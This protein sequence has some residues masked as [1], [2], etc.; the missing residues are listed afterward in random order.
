MNKK[1]LISLNIIFILIL[2]QHC[3]AGSWFDK[4]EYAA[5]RAKFMEQIP[6]GVAV[7]L[8]ATTPASD[9]Q[10][11]QSSDFF[12]FT[13]VEIP[14]AVLIMDGM[15]KVST[16]FF[17]ISETEAQGEGISLELVRKPTEVTGIERISPLE[18]LSS[19][20]SRLSLQ[21]DVFYTMFRSEELSRE[22][23]NEKFRALQRTMTMN[24][25]D[26]RLTRE[27][28][29]VKRLKEKFP[30]ITVKDCSPL[31]WNLRK[32]KSPAEIDLLRKAGQIG[33]K[34]HIAVM[35]ATRPGIS[36]QELA[37]LFEYVCK[38]EMAQELAFYVILMSGPNHAFGHY[39]KHDRVLKN[40]DFI[41]LDAGPEYGYYN[42]D[43][44]IT[45]PANGKFSAKQKKI[46]EMAY[47]IRKTC[48]DNYRPG[49][50]FKDVGE[51]VKQFLIQEG[52]D[53]EDRKFRGLIRYG[54]Y[55][56]SIGLATHDPMGTF[57]G[58]EE[59]LRP[60]F[61]FACDINIPYPDQE[62]GIRLEDTVVITEKGYENLSQ[63][64][65]R[66]VAEIEDLMK[67]K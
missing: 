36:E 40:G 43:I 60:G 23:T 39:H 22:N 18:R 54:G 24:M 41:I 15:S 5:R 61:V 56:H 20:L 57:S 3:I 25:W 33:V 52:Y 34:A 31:F 29:F 63:G 51:K 53:P 66:S 14:N 4:S 50:T 38:K 17:S 47:G 42:A 1:I 59:V 35:K 26:G 12:Y 67:K 21:T 44:S 48:L 37:A 10:F 28:Q 19:T 58:P 62:M 30:H 9:R 32:I 46:Y 6:D 49:I 64:I 16:L 7:I 27:L 8:G 45:F 13:G 55:N 65:P 2:A 11:F